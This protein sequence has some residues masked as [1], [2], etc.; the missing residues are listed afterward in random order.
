MSQKEVRV[1]TIDGH[2]PPCQF[3][4]K[5]GFGKTYVPDNDG[6]FPL[7]TRLNFDNWIINPDE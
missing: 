4:S 3:L 1:V 5:I 6:E 2:I 7:T